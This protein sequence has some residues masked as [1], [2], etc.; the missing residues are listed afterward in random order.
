MSKQQ[1]HCSQVAGL[2]VN[3]RRL[4]PPHR[5]RSISPAIQTGALNPAMDDP[6]ILSGRDMRLVAEPAREK[7][8]AAR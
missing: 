8:L 1:L 2:L 5:V 6:S 7:E 4:G 3:L